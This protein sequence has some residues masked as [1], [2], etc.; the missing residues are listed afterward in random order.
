MVYDFNNVNL[1]ISYSGGQHYVTGFSNGSQIEAE[2]KSDKWTPHTGAKGDT[3]YA[4]NND[5][6]GTIKFKIKIDSPSNAVLNVLNQNDETFQAQ[7]VDGND[8]TNGKAGGSNCVIMKPANFS[9]GTE[10]TDNEWTI[11]VP[12][13]NI[14]Y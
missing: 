13:L 7:I 9:R 2:R 6:S 5:N 3:T 1:I 4:K 11:A 14:E 12:N 8:S 10:I